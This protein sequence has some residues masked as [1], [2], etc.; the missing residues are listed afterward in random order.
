MFTPGQLATWSRG[1]WTALPAAPITGFSN[2][3]RTLRPN[4][5]FVA[6][7][8]D[9][10]DGHEYLAAAQ[11]AGAAGAIVSRAHAA[12]PLPQLVVEDPLAA[13][14]AIAGEHR[15]AFPGPVLGISGSVGKTST[16]DLVALL[17]GGAP[18]VLATEGN[19]N[20]HIGVPLTLTRLDPV[21]HRYAVIEAGI[22]APGEMKRLAGLIEPDL[23]IITLVAPA[24][25][26]ELG[27]VEGVAREKAALPA[28]VRAAGVAVFPHQC[29]QFS[30]FRDLS[31]RTLTVEP[32]A[33]LA[34]RVRPAE[35][36]KD[37]VYFAVTQRGDTTALAIAYGP[38][39]PLVFTMQR[40]SA[41]MAQNA[42]LA[43]C[44]ALW[45]GVPPAAIQER[46]TAWQPVKWRGELRREDGRL[47]YLDFYNA[48]PA[49][50]ADALE[51]FASL[52]PAGLPRAYVLGCMEELGPRA[53]DYHR[54][55]GRTVHL[56]PGDRLFIVGDQAAALRAGL[57]ENG[58]PA[59][60]IEVVADA[61]AVAAFLAGFRGAIFLKGSRRY[62]LEKAL[63]AVTPLEPVTC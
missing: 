55:L 16:K 24:H 54:Q 18:T 43:I 40:V 52:A 61:T 51:N 7:K 48:N 10:R 47:L 45:L 30:V 15:H 23:A 28:A 26:L 53:A 17:L 60:Q 42:V 34:S 49:S 19:L 12:L 39:P 29:A 21:R 37:K 13:L 25:L 41:G 27:D 58:N 50:M 38:P 57:L 36:P 1:R 46:L 11:A 35:P 32:A 3:T 62:Q 20:N 5:L 33:L 44:A 8:T 9:R 59:P 31:V 6:L 22:S 63:A 56:R 14:Q 4:Q 2:D